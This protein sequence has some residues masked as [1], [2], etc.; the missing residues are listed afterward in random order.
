M[1]H[2]FVEIDCK[3]K[4]NI[5]KHIYIH[6]SMCMFGRYCILLAFQ[7]RMHFFLEIIYSF[8]LFFFSYFR[9]AY[10]ET[11]YITAAP[12]GTIGPITVS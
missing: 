2:E 10:P 11:A 4:K 9:H 8:V 6:I 12:T 3:T 1:M 5:I 7:L